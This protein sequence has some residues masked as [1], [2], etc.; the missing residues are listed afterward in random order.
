MKKDAS[1]KTGLFLIELIAMILLFALCSA[2]C[3]RIFSSA[4]T[5]SDDSRA[6]SNSSLVAQSA[7]ECFK[8][9]G[10]LDETADIM[11]GEL[12]DGRVLVFYDKDWQNTENL[13][14]AR[15]YLDISSASKLID[16]EAVDIKVLEC[17]SS[18]EI[19]SIKVKA[20]DYEY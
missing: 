3:M 15:F 12:K 18:E 1:S 14:N 8:A 10:S 7:A 17:G 2:V 16:P 6:L 9:T 19:F 20:V 13:E 5:L 4:K 11:E